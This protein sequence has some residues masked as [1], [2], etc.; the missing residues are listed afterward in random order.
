M[1]RYRPA[2]KKYYFDPAKYKTYLDQMKAEFGYD[3]PKVAP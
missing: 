2:L 1:A 3:Y